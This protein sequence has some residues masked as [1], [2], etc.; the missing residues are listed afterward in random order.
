[1]EPAISMAAKLCLEVKSG[2]LY[3][4]FSQCHLVKSWSCKAEFCQSDYVSDLPI[5]EL[6]VDM[7]RRS[8][9]LLMK[10]LKFVFQTWS[11]SCSNI[12]LG[13]SNILGEEGINLVN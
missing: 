2:L 1:M 4:S 10:L 6:E 13:G 5:K 7:T 12:F 11:S 9:P 8:Q 3:L